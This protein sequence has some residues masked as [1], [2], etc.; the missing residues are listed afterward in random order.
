M[1]HEPGK[2]LKKSKRCNQQRIQTE[3]AIA[4]KKPILYVIQLISQPTQ[5]TTDIA[6]QT[7]QQSTNSR[8]HVV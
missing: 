5:I 3:S 1:I 6:K 2:E 8:K 7:E 4:D